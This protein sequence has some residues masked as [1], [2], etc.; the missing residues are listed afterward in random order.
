MSRYYDDEL[1]HHGIKGQSWGAQ[2][3]PP[4]PLNA[5]GKA[6][7]R[8][9]LK[10]R[11]KAAVDDRKQRRAAKKAAKLEEKEAAKAEKRKETLDKLATSPTALYKNRSAYTTQELKDALDRINTEQKLH[12]MSMKELNRGKEVLDTIIGY[13]QTAVKAYSTASQLK[14]NM[15]SLFGKKKDDDSDGGESKKKDSDSRDSGPSVSEMFEKAKEMRDNAK[16]KAKERRDSRYRP[17]HG[18]WDED[19]PLKGTVEGKGTSRKTESGRDRS[20]A[21]KHLYREGATYD[22]TGRET[23]SRREPT[24]LV[25]SRRRRRH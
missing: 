23:G 15:D 5:A 19:G 6:S 11:M 22:S 4:Y 3:G 20:F 1:Y 12:E 21:S 9:R 13:G 10:A 25:P 24:G 18:E 7:F 8:K 2:N 14:K 17:Y 16:S